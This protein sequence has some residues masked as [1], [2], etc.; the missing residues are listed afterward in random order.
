M[1]GPLAIL[2]GVLGGLMI[3]ER[4]GPSEAVLPM[5]TGIAL[6]LL[7]YIFRS[8]GGV[9]IAVVAVALLATACMQR[10]LDG[11]ESS[12]LRSQAMQYRSGHLVGT[13][14]EDPSGPRFVAHALMRVASFDGTDAGGR[15]VVAV[16][17][18]DDASRLRVLESGDMLTIDGTL[19]PLDG[20][21]ARLRWR[22]AV[23][24]V[25]VNDL[26]SFSGPTNPIARL[27]NYL[28]ET[29]LRGTSVLPPTERSLLAGFLLGDTRSVPEQVVNDFRSSGLGH[30]LA[31]SGANVAFVLALVGPILR[32]FGLGTRF[33]G[34]CMVLLIF[35]T[36]TRWEPSV[37]RAIAMATLVMFATYVGRP[38]TGARV[39]TLAVTA[40]LLAD[41]FLLH[42][43]GFLLSSAACAG[44]IWIS[45]WIAVRLRG[46]LVLREAI[47]TTM[48]AQLG[49]TPVLLPVF[50]TVPLVALLANLLAAPVVGPLTVWGLITG[51][52]G[53]AVT[54]VLGPGAPWVLQLPTFT[55]VRW[56]RTVASVAAVHP[57]AVDARG[58]WAILS[59]AAIAGVAGVVRL[60]ARGGIRGE[61]D[62]PSASVSGSRRS[63]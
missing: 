58:A 29:V 51:A 32:R 56:I 41:P 59:V 25:R 54:G 5:L 4:F 48:G 3:G 53:G 45:P 43:V 24:R 38:A 52:I 11:I 8:R 1:T 35:G 36:M 39:L 2:L 62:R 15:T 22:H 21:D 60:Q 17:G 49:V 27:A 9:I 28:R 34:G 14:V 37:L 55:L 42:S 61:G 18:G 63:P 12:P 20:Y 47:A 50:G 16:A 10:A 26:I 33:A 23:A 46:P 13:L 6:V 30:L 31:V 19:E 40:L 44:I 57:L 7:A